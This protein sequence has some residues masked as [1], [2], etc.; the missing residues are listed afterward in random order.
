MY[1]FHSTLAQGTNK[2]SSQHFAAQSG[3]STSHTTH[4][5]VVDAHLPRP[6]TH[7]TPTFTNLVVCVGGFARNPETRFGEGLREI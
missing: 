3:L 5:K 2:A 7:G 6:K 1:N 4:R